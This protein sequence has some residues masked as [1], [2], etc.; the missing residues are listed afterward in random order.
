MFVFGPAGVGK[1]IASIQ[2]PNA[3]I[4]DTEKGTDFYAN[5]INKAN[6]LVLQTH[7][8]DEIKEEVSKVLK[9]FSIDKAK[10]LDL[11]KLKLYIGS[12]IKKEKTLKFLEKISIW[13]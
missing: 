8:I 2:F 3:Y 13:I 11:E 6:S 9:S 1:T 10:E 4:I 5:M 7:N 12:E